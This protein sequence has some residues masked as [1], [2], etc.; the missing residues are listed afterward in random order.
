MLLRGDVY[1]IS[2]HP[3]RPLAGAVCQPR[4]VQ[5]VHIAEQTLKDEDPQPHAD[6]FMESNNFFNGL[7]V[8]D[9]EGKV[10]AA[11]DTLA[12]LKG[13]ELM[14]ETG[15]KALEARGPTLSAPY[16]SADGNPVVLMTYPIYDASGEYNGYIGGTIHL[17]EPNV[18]NDIFGT[19]P[20]SGESGTYAYV[21][22]PSGIILYHPDPGRL[23][24]SEAANAVVQKLMRGQR[25]YEKVRNT[26]GKLYLAGFANVAENGWGI[27][28]QTPVGEIHDQAYRVVFKEISY[29]LPFFAL[30]LLVTFL[31]A[32]RLAAPFSALAETADRLA[33]GY[34]AESGRKPAFLSRE[35]NQLHRTIMLAMDQLQKQAEHYLH[36]S[37]TDPLT[38][39]PNRRTMNMWISERTRGQYPF[40][41][42]MM[43]IDHFKRVNDTYGHQVGDEVL[44]HA[45]RTMLSELRRGDCCCRYG[46]EEFAVLLPDTSIDDAFKIAERIRSKLEREISPTG[47]PVTISC[48]LAAWPDDADTAHALVEA[49]DLALY[50]AKRA[51]RNRTAIYNR[52]MKTQP[53]SGAHA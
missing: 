24:D 17:A 12:G 13:T 15:R 20:A 9:R 16:R 35:A 38:G 49:A 48:G 31:M 11:S 1:A 39:L 30:L 27:V 42:I 52:E 34:Q 4:N 32:R 50:E 7:I 44:R 47:S 36:E 18:L 51:G 8:V 14:N 3:L 29:T 33:A 5:P 43:D 6:H 46:G 26:R 22:D 28:V 10:I 45:A 23:G 21:V 41:I 53:E 37:L 40:S 25:G 2:Q 19:S